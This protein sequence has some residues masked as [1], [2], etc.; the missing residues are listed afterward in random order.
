MRDPG[1]DRN[2]A[3]CDLVLNT[4]YQAY[5]IPVI[6]GLFA[7]PR[8]PFR[9]GERIMIVKPVSSLRSA[10]VRTREREEVVKEERKRV[11]TG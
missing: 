3:S 7:F 10:G 1:R 11:E 6:E 5:I 8:N 2:L 9:A 4:E